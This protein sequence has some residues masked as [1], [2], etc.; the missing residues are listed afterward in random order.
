VV[1]EL[2]PVLDLAGGIAVHAQGG[3][4]A[5]YRPVVSGL[6][7]GCH[8]DA[9]A[10]ARAYRERLCAARCYVAD[11]DAIT[12]G[13]AQLD[14]LCA[15]AGEDAFGG[16]LLIDAGLRSAADAPRLA[17]VPGCFVAGLETFARW[18]DLPALA[19]LRAG[20]VVSVDVRDGVTL[21]NGPWAGRSAAAAAGYVVAHGAAEVLVLDLARVG[22]G[23]GPDLATLD[24]VRRAA[25]GVRLLAGGGVRHDADLRRLG[26]SGVDGVL[27]ASA[28]H[29]GALTLPGQ[30]PA[31]DTR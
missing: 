11:L 19:G 22:R 28:L 29:A 6:V 23:E 25:P 12:G 9:R 14:L 26:A 13:P 3:D 21:R 16:T 15:L 20:L 1:P 10:L 27:V 5:G 8:G 30:S 18:E 4:R 24:A 31:S 7:S 17:R 2:I